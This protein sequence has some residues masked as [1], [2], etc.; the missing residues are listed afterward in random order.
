MQIREARLE[1]IQQ[2]QLVRRSVRE[3]ILSDPSLVTDADCADY[4]TRRGKGWVAETADLIVGFAIADLED[5]NIWALFL[6]PEY[7]NMGLGKQLH[8]AMMDW[9]FS[10]T[11]HSVWLGTEI[12]S[13]A[14]GFYKKMGWTEVGM[15]GKNEIK[16]E[17]NYADWTNQH[18]K[19]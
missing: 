17:M 19:N 12:D 9:Y 8:K 6:L 15:H 2:I 4:L 7:E 13:R 14:V 16:F 10:Q 5:H 1:D 3:N 11:Q 18:T